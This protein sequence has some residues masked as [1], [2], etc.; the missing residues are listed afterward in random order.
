MKKNLFFAVIAALILFSAS[1]FADTVVGTNAGGWRTGWT[2][3]QDGNPYWDG[4][5]SDSNQFY[6]IGN[7]LT[8]TGGFSGNTVPGAIPYW[9]TVGGGSDPFHMVPTGGANGVAIKLEVAGYAGTNIFGYND[10]TPHDLLF[11]GGN[12][13]QLSATFTPTGNYFFY[14]KSKGGTEG[15]FTS[16]MS[17]QEDTYQHFAIFQAPNS[18]Y[19]IGMED[20]RYNS[21]YDYNDMIVKLSY[22]PVPEPATMLLLGLGLVG[23]V[24]IGRRFKK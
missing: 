11:S 8:N 19:W 5:S 10:G 21:D 2:A 4:N 22:L 9:G 24:G 18:V 3:D 20:L 1:A 15:T 6:N 14:L 13:P 23:L 12:A 7:Y 16:N 17:N